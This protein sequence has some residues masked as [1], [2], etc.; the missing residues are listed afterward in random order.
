[1]RLFFRRTAAK[2]PCRCGYL[3][4]IRCQS[5]L[6]ALYDQPKPFLRTPPPA[7]HI[8]S[9]FRF[10]K[11]NACYA[12]F[13]KVEYLLP[14]LYRIGY[15]IALRIYMGAYVSSNR[16]CYVRGKISVTIHPWWDTLFSIDKLA[17]CP[18]TSKNPG[19]GVLN[20]VQ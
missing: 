3:N 5:A 4:S 8:R 19:K 20:V 15:V 18:K 6:M 1:M 13:Y 17:D 12:G 2:K 11:H 10:A 7:A 16:Y 9:F 14:E